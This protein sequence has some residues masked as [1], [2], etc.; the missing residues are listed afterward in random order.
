[1]ILTGLL[2]TML[3]ELSKDGVGCTE[4][5][6][7]P[8][9]GL[10][11]RPPE[12]SYDQSRCSRDAARLWVGDFIAAISGSR[13]SARTTDH[14]ASKRECSRPTAAK[15]QASSGERGALAFWEASSGPLKNPEYRRAIGASTHLGASCVPLWAPGSGSTPVEHVRRPPCDWWQA[16]ATLWPSKSSMPCATAWTRYSMHGA[17]RS[18]RDATSRRGRRS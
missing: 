9:S 6:W 13:W 11:Q 12:S 16:F 10:P 15:Q 8:S 3:S 1:M 2:C 4:T 5:A 18:T 7:T 14:L 17:M